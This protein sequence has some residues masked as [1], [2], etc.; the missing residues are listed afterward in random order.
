VHDG[1]LESGMAFTLD[2]VAFIPIGI[3]TDFE[4]LV[5]ILAHESFHVFQR[6]Y[7]DDTRDLMRFMGFER[8]EKKRFDLLKEMYRIRRNP[9]TCDVPIFIRFGK[10]LHAHIFDDGLDLRQGSDVT[11]DAETL[12]IT[13]PS[14]FE[15]PYELTAYGFERV[16]RNRLETKDDELLR[17]WLQT[18]K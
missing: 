1:T 4:R 11:I 15:H 17:S 6:L 8:D 13:G 18:S 16:V 9:D 14:T 12:S 10:Y 2:R 7:P 5:S 3:L